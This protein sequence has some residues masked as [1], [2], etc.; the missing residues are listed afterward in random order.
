MES[1]GI[2]F[3]ETVSP[4]HIWI[5]AETKTGEERVA[6]TPNDASILIQKGFKISVEKSSLRAFRDDQYSSVGANIVPFGSWK[7]N[8]PLSALI[9]GL[10]ELE[11]NDPP[12]LLHRHIFFA[13][14]FKD[15]EGWKELLHRFKR[16][17]GLLWDLEFLVDDNKRR[18]AAFGRA[19]GVVGAALGLLT[20][21]L[22]HLGENVPPMES[23]RN[24]AELVEFVRLQIKRASSIVGR[25]PKI[26]VLGA[27][28][29]CGGG[30][31]WFARQAG[32]DV[33]EW[34][35]E[36]TKNGGP[37]TEFL[38]VDV[39]LN[40]IYLTSKIP[41]FLTEDLLARRK[42]R[43]LSVFVDVSCDSNNPN[44]PFPI[45]SGLTSLSSPVL[46]LDFGGAPLH[47]IAIDHLPTLIPS[48]SSSEFSAAL[49][50]H[51]LDLA[52]PEKSPVWDRAEDIFRNKLSLA[53]N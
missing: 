47:I 26:L 12:S 38:D 19:A 50:P 22:K 34:D 13:H 32:V 15:Q 52:K 31:S 7:T 41:P 11:D 35:L 5:R 18:V 30:A 44:N 16:G 51:L 10:K 27:K 49:L 6:L 17:N 29:R 23:W 43:K 37:F 39:L 24:S 40:A 21:A 9:L 46:S 3:S 48:E 25:S 1:L 33:I 20:W 8:A 42:D 45:Y 28:G 53:E 14:C 2:V 36:E 4:V